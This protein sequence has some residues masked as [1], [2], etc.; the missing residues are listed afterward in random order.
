MKSLLKLVIPPM[1]RIY[2]RVAYLYC[3]DALLGMRIRFVKT[4]SKRFLHGEQLQRQFSVRQPV[5]QT[6]YS[7]NKVYN[8][9]QALLHINNLVIAPNELFSFWRLIGNPSQ[10][11]GYREGRSIVGNE[12]SSNIGG[13][14]CQ[15]SGIL[16]Y[17][18]I[19]AGLKIV[20]HHTHSYDLY[21]EETRYTPLGSDATVA[22]GHK[23]LR[24]VNVLNQ[25]ICFRFD[26]T[27]TYVEGW[28]CTT[29]ELQKYDI[30]F[31][32]DSGAKGKKVKSYSIDSQGN[33]TLIEEMHYQHYSQPLDHF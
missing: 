1:W 10:R 4:S 23:D 16:Y 27:D 17:L 22:Y 33:R 28:V 5:K 32:I 8:I 29:H 19:Q 9:Q 7:A 12:L 20:E 14:L 25:P 18:A 30:A 21:T 13:G 11:R 24:I 2:L 31:E 6:E 3:T 15:L 26:V